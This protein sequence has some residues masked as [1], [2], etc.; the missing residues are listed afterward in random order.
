MHRSIKRRSRLNSQ[1][2][3]TWTGIRQHFLH[4]ERSASL[5]PP[6]EI[7]HLRRS[8]DFHEN[9]EEQYSC[10]GWQWSPRQGGECQGCSQHRV[11]HLFLHA[12][13]NV[14]SPNLGYWVVYAHSN[15]WNRPKKLQL[16]GKYSVKQGPSKTSSKI[17]QLGHLVPQ[18]H[19][20]STSPQPHPPALRFAPAAMIQ[21]AHVFDRQEHFVT[22]LWCL[23]GVS[24]QVTASC[25]ICKSEMLLMW[26]DMGS[27]L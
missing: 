23:F 22:S 11:L 5:A 13:Q 7:E 17:T 26:M 6:F 4:W 19:Q 16:S 27:K 15:P 3:S 14:S 18:N 1:K 8:S 24:L 9:T 25:G 12:I 21:Y 20:V 10:E 2:S